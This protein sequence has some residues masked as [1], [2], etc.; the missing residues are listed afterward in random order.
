MKITK[1]ETIEMPKEVESVCKFVSWY[2]I[3]YNFGGMIIRWQYSIREHIKGL[4]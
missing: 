3:S 4:F 1:I 2:P